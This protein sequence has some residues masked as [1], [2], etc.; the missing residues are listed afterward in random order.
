MRV[1]LLILFF[2]SGINSWAQQQYWVYFKDKPSKEAAVSEKTKLRYKQAGYKPTIKDAAVNQQYI[3]QVCAVS[4][5]KVRTKSRWLNAVSI[6]VNNKNQ[7]NKI[8]ALPFVKMTSV[9]KKMHKPNGLIDVVYKEKINSHEALQPG[10][11]MLGGQFLAERGFNGEGMTIAVIDDG[12]RNANQ[13]QA[14][15]HVFSQHRVLGYYDFV[16][17]DTTVFDN[18]AGTHGQAVWGFMAA[19]L[20]GEYIGT[21]PNANYWLFRTEAGAFENE[22]EE[23]YWLAAAEMA[24]SVGVDIIT[25]SLNYT[26]F[27]D[28]INSH[29]YSDLDGNTTIITNAAD[30]A[31]K[32]G[33]FVVCSAGNYGSGNWKYV[34]A[35]ADG[36]SVLAVGAVDV[37]GEIAGFSSFGPTF[38]GRIKPD[39]LA[40]GRQAAYV[41][42]AGTV[43]SGNGTSYAAPLTTGLVACL[44][45]A[46]PN[47]TANDLRLAIIETAQQYNNPTDQ[48]GNGLSDFCAA[49]KKLGGVFC[50]ETELAGDDEIAYAY[51][52][53]ATKQIELNLDLHGS[54]MGTISLYALTGDLVKQFSFEY[55]NETGLYPLDIALPSESLLH[56]VIIIQAILDGKES[57][58]KVVTSN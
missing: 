28:N 31:A 24:D 27:D 23:D 37:N 57:A 8:T 53:E 52:N 29:T 19:R 13:M 9:V 41:S 40:W 36:D 49:Y 54:G 16:D 14:F 25:S 30:E 56:Q 44:W 20:P 18:G 5:G 17:N 39:V 42:N 46:F 32:R 12:F 48:R 45:Q 51:Y 21:A 58:I 38:D 34:G 3:Q 22:V 33:I 26:L 6:E 1:T 4:G 15:N 11:T 35:P 43:L 7:L 50:F 55:I 10:I 47:K 2:I